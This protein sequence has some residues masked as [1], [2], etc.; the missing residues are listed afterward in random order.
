MYVYM[1]V[2]VCVCVCECTLAYI[3]FLNTCMHSYTHKY[4]LINCRSIRS[5]RGKVV[6]VFGEVGF[7]VLVRDCLKFK[8]ISFF[9]PGHLETANCPLRLGL[10]L[11]EYLLSTDYILSK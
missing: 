2:C 3:L 9:W 8:I 1:Y 6:D 10:L 4:R 11:F 5:K 7:D